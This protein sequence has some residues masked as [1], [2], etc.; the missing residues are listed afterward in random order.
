MRNSRKIKKLRNK[1]AECALKNIARSVR[2]F[3]VT[4]ETATPVSSVWAG[5]PDAVPALPQVA[6][7]AVLPFATLSS[8][9]EQGYFADGLAEDLITDLSKVD[10]LL[11]IARHSSFAYRDRSMYLRMIAKELGVRYL[12]EGSVRRAAARVGSMRNSST[13]PAPAVFGPNAWTATSRISSP[14]RTKSSAR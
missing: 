9:A 2:I 12:I 14:C 11:V 1:A 4:W 7:I 6:S 5:G 13:P 8:D 3:R 10:G